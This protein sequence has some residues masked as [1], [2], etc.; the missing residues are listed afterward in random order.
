VGSSSAQNTAT[1]FSHGPTIPVYVVAFDSAGTAGTSM[2]TAGAGYGL[3]WNLFPTWDGRYRRL[4]IGLPM[5]VNLPEAGA[6]RFSLG[7]TIGT[8]NNLLSM[9]VAV[10]MVNT[11]GEDGDSGTGALLGDFSKANIRF[12]FGLNFNLG[13]GGSPDP[14]YVASASKAGQPVASNPPPNYLGGW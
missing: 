13:S 10:D 4:T 7:G 9:G 3:N 6:F 1:T 11:T 8:L 5:Y 14:S 12:V 2:L